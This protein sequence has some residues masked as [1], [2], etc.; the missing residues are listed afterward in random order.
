M[1]KKTLTKS[2]LA[3]IILSRYDCDFLT[4]RVWRIKTKNVLKSV[5]KSGYIAD[6]FKLDKE[7]HVY[8][9]AHQ[10][11]FALYHNYLPECIDHADRDMLNNAISN[12][13]PAT[14][15]QNNWN[16]G[17]RSDSKSGVRGVVKVGKRWRVSYADINSK[18]TYGGTFDT[19]EEASKVYNKAT[20]FRGAFQCPSKVK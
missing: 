5:S 10:I 18:W 13:R 14:T 12:L 6:W 7:R 9:A 19:I 8:I 17:A 20:A 1:S 15:K 2:E 3:N 16:T 11:V 4:G